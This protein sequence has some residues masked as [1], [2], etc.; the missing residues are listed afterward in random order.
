MAMMHR[1]NNVSR[2][3]FLAVDFFCGAGGT[4]RGLIDAGGYVMA[5]VNKDARCER[6]YIENNINGCIDYSPVR[7]LNYDIFPHSPEYPG[8]AASPRHEFAAGSVPVREKVP[9][10]AGVIGKRRRYRSSRSRV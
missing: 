6:T 8:G 10:G 4:T 9:A 7:F 3:P 2:A 1:D 5:G